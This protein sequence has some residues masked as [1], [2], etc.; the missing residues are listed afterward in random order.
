[1]NKKIL[2]LLNR[3][4]DFNDRSTLTT[5]ERLERDNSLNFLSQGIVKNKKFNHFIFIPKLI[6]K[7]IGNSFFSNILLNIFETHRLPLSYLKIFYI[8]W[9]VKPDILYL[10]ELK[11][12]IPC[13][14][15]K[16]Y[17]KRN[18]FLHLDIRENPITQNQSKF[19]NNLLKNNSY[20]IDEVSTISSPL[21]NLLVKKYN[22]KKKIINCFFT[23]PTKNFIPKLKYIRDYKQSQ[24]IKF[25]FFGDIK[26]DRNIHFFSDVLNKLPKN[27]KY[28]F[29]IYGN[30]IDEA[31]LNII[32]NNNCNPNINYK[33]ILDYNKA[34]SILRNYDI[35]VLTNEINI[36]SKYTIPGKFWEYLS[37]G[38]PII[39]NNRPSL[40]GFFENYNIGWFFKT[41][42]ELKNC[43]KKIIEKKENLTSK[44]NNSLRLFN[45]IY[46]K[47]KNLIEIRN[48]KKY[49]I[50]KKKKILFITAYKFPPAIRVL[51][52]VQSLNKNGYECAVLS[53]PFKNQKE[54][55]IWKNIKIFRPK[56]LKNDFFDKLIFKISFFS[57]RWFLSIYKITKIY[58]PD[59]IHLH[60]IWIGKSTFASTKSIPVIID[61]LE[62]MP[63]AILQYFKDLRGIHLFINKF[64]FNYHRLLSYE[65]NLLNK[66]DLAIVV[67]KEAYE[68]V[69]NEHKGFSKKRLVLVENLESKEFI[70]THVLKK[71]LFNKKYFNITYIGTFGPHRGLDTLIKAFIYIKKSNQNIKLNL[72]G[73]KENVYLETLKEMINYNGLSK[74]IKIKG[75]IKPRDVIS[76]ISQSDVCIV[77]HNSNHH[78]DTTLPW[79]LSQYMLIKKPVLVSSSRPLARIVKKAS[80]GMIFQAN[81]PKDCAS[82]IISLKVN[83]KSL[84][85]FGKNGFEYVFKKGNNWEQ[86]SLKN[87][88]KAYNQIFDN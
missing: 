51:K 86:K 48:N 65:K 32:T 31:Y 66:V 82:K 22:F 55:E 69:L 53:P 74:Y 54:F 88:L 80:S 58:K 2:I 19:L 62:N 40:K 35:A 87:L 36:N 8:F 47:N 13:L 21:K 6:N 9:K 64:F 45:K 24:P 52:E 5:I 76:Y 41:S 43:L 20:L 44:K 18:I 34:S 49:K 68:R 11:Y 42:K 3:P 25:C 7:F 61:L 16:K 60:D 12:L 10:R 79:K 29:D 75:W 27:L 83:R 70:K 50:T 38:L 85:K 14:I 63:A 28:N 56:F 77:P 71:R 33:G 39:S 26:K 30:V 59:A 84:L 4:F 57:P 23:L 73:A 81:N 46:D 1:M 78:T 15:I 37:C 67:A 72:V 17:L